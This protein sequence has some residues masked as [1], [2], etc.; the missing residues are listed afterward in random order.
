MRA[1]AR[2][3]LCVRRCVCAC[4]W[5]GKRIGHGQAVK[6]RG[7]GGQATIMVV[8]VTASTTSGKPLSE[9][10]LRKVVGA[11]DLALQLDGDKAAILQL[12][13]RK[14]HRIAPNLS[15]AIGTEIAAKLMG[16]AGGL[17]ALSQMPACNVQVVPPGVPG[18]SGG[19][20]GA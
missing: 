5:L 19:T 8:S 1:R 15:N 18:P 20:H 9:E 11:A 2:V 10:D 14:M 16:V 13:Q 3:H 7:T 17:V 6:G 12:V 4:R